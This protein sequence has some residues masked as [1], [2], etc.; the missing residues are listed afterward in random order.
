M[1]LVVHTAACTCWTPSNGILVC[2]GFPFSVHQYGAYSIGDIR[3][4]GLQR[5]DRCLASAG[6]SKAA[7]QEPEQRR[8]SQ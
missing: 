2:E 7:R 5:L 8:H 4:G 1:A 6:I 3:A